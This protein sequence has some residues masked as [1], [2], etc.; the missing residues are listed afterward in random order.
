M[1]DTRNDRQWE[2]GN[3]FCQSQCVEAAEVGSST[4]TAK[5]T[6][7]VEVRTERSLT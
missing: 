4:T 2:L 1:A 3:V 7:Y 5:D 6:Y